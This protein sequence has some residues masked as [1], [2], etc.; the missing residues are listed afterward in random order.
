MADSLSRKIYRRN[1]L[2]ANFQKTLEEARGCIS[3]TRATQAKY[4]G[5]QNN[6]N[7]LCKSLNEI[8]DQILAI[9][10]PENI[11][12]DVSESIGME[13]VHEDSEQS[14]ERRDR[15]ILYTKLP[16]LEF[17]VFK[18]NPLEWQ[19]FY[20]QF[21][22]SIH[23]NKTLSDIDRFNY[24]RRYLAGQALATISGLTLNS[25]NYKEALDILIDRYGN[26]QV[27]I[28][29]HMETLVKINKVKNMENLEALW[30]L[31]NVIDN[32]IRNLKSLRIESSTYGYLLVPLLKE[33]ISDELNMIISRKFSGNVWTLELMLKYFNEELQAKETCVPFKSTSNEKDKV[34]YKNRAGYTAS[35]L[36]SESYESKSQKCVY[37]LENHSP[38]Q[39]KRVTNRQSRIDIL[40][41]SYRCFLCLKS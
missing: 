33:K 4:L 39:R 9:L 37:C 7:R 19:S 14:F 31:Y 20:D 27:L 23:Q 12:S 29:A 21:K 41:K 6:I 26:P 30:K 15:K 32:C 16:K 22:I 25:Q 10:E 38:S 11:E 24:L 18:G 17:P 2:S 1:A 8:D 28:T 35:C 40:K 3:D 34:K 5:L 36:H 13:P